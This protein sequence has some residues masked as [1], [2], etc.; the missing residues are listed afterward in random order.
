M[1][2]TINICL[3]GAPINNGNLG[4]QALT[5]SMIN[6]LE[7]IAKNNCLQFKYHIFEVSPDNNKKLIFCQN[8]DINSSKIDVHKLTRL[9]NPLSY[10]KH[11]FINIQSLCFIKKCKLAIDLTEGDSF[12]DIYGQERFDGNVGNKLLIMR[13][14][15]PLIL[16]PQT[17]GPFSE[18]NEK[19]ARNVFDRCFAMI[20]R[21]YASAKCVEE[22]SGKQIEVTSDLAFQLPYKKDITVSSAHFKV[23]INISGLLITEKVETGLNTGLALKT[24]YDGFISSVIEYLISINADIYLIS[25]VKEDYVACQKYNELYLKTNLVDEFE[26]PI[27]AKSYISNLDLFIGSRMHATIAAF[28]SGVPTIPVAYSR[29]FDTMFKVLDYDR[30]IDLTSLK[31]DEAIKTTI[32]YIQNCDSLKQEVSTSLSMMKKYEKKTYKFFEASLMKILSRGE[33]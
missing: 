22:I 23:G 6:L 33:E 25:H 7:K 21:D 9:Y 8:L 24:E 11:P 4:C 16:G 12:S 20:T 29:K 32:S 3:Y 28:S 13:L 18:P 15:T 17:Y 10:L 30:T 2:K 14:G 26:N 5:Y 31:T 19:K 27:S 1:D